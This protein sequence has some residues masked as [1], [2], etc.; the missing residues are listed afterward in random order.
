[1]RNTDISLICNFEGMAVSKCFDPFVHILVVLT[2]TLNSILDSVLIL[3]K[4]GPLTK[5]WLLETDGSTV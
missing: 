3:Q 4:P 2:D 5:V 1:M